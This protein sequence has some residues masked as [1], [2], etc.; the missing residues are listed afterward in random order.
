[1]FHSD[2]CWKSKLVVRLI[3]LWVTSASEPG[4]ES[5]SQETNVRR[6]KIQMAWG[7]TLLYIKR[8]AL[9]CW[10][11][12]AMD[13]TVHS[14]TKNA[15]NCERR[16]WREGLTNRKEK[17]GKKDENNKKHKGKRRSTTTP[18]LAFESENAHYHKKNIT[19]NKPQW[20]SLH[21]K[22]GC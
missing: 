10:L 15:A 11:H 21:I 16:R 13:D 19:L 12:H 4:N 1:M 7:S 8:A 6:E 17:K 5:D 18:S 14:Q 20:R 22:Y 2:K 3:R 9:W